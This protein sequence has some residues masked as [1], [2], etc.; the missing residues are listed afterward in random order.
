MY[1][2]GVLDAI[3][4]YWTEYRSSVLVR[5]L[6]LEELGPKGADTPWREEYQTWLADQLASRPG[7]L[8]F[9]L[10]SALTMTCDLDEQVARK[11]FGDDAVNVALSCFDY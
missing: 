2:E 9:K 7:P 3:L 8:R 11:R 5:P 4:E 6:K 10:A 1:S